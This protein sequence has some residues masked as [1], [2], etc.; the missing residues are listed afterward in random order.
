MNTSTLL[1]LTPSILLSAAFIG[2]FI[3]KGIPL[4]IVPGARDLFDYFF[5]SK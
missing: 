1:S 4:F 5:A 2:A 3:V